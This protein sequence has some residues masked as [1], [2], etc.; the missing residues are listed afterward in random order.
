M[1]PVFLSIGHSCYDIVPYG[2]VV[3][4]ATAYSTITVRNLG[5]RA[6]AVTA[7]GTDLDRHNSVL[8]RID[9]TCHKAPETTI[10][11]NRYGVDGRRQQFILG[12]GGKLQ[13]HHIPQRWKNADIVYLCPLADEVEPILA[14]HFNRALIGVT[15][16]GWQNAGKT[17]KW[18][19]RIPMFWC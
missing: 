8:D 19:Y 12:I 7:V 11:E 2:Y 17:P 3:G 16:Q 18:S 4:G 15:P 6:C 13:S 1:P 5:C 14:Q 10:F 9:V